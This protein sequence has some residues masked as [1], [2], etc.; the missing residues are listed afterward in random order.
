VKPAHRDERHT[1]S[2]L[3]LPRGVDVVTGQAWMGHA[4]VAATNL[5]CTTWGIC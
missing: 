3:W 4:S 2:L 1:G 5:I